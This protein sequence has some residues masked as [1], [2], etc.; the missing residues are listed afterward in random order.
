MSIF[1]SFLMTENNADTSS[2]A[3]S[4][5][6]NSNLSTPANENNALSTEQALRVYTQCFQEVKLLGM[7][8]LQRSA[9]NN[10]SVV[11]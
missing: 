9:V 3:H 2:A 8:D 5:A 10:S 11:S 4:S 1:A 6:E 7:I